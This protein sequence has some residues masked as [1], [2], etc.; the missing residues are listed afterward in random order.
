MNYGWTAQQL[1]FRDELRAFI[2]GRRTPELS[3]EHHKTYVGGPVTQCFRDA[4][5]DVLPKECGGQDKGAFYLFILKK[6]LE[7]WG[8]PCDAL[9]ALSVGRSRCARLAGEHGDAILDELGYDIEA[10][11][12]LRADRVASSQPL[13]D[14]AEY[15]P[16]GAAR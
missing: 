16:P 14:P 2:Q 3:G 10:I 9:A 15:S 4:L 5:D 6:E 7:Y 13:F 8:M 1:H 12:R 11:A